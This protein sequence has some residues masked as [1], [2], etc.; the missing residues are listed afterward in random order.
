MAPCSLRVPAERLPGLGHSGLLLPADPGKRQDTACRERDVITV[1]CGVVAAL[2]MSSPTSSGPSEVTQMSSKG[3]K[4]VGAPESVPVLRGVGWG[5]EPFRGDACPTA[6]QPGD[7]GHVS[8]DDP[9]D[10]RHPDV[11]SSGGYWAIQR[12]G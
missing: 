4:T 10:S 5:R 8:R 12:H 7:Q 1:H 11:M 9:A 6:P 3:L 2:G